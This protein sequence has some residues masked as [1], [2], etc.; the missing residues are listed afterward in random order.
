M[1]L[2]ETEIGAKKRET[3]FADFSRI[4]KLFGER[5]KLFVENV[6]KTT[7]E[8]N[9]RG[10]QFVNLCPPPFCSLNPNRA[11]KVMESSGQIRGQEWT[12]HSVEH[13]PEPALVHRHPL[14]P[15]GGRGLSQAHRCYLW[16][17]E[18]GARDVLVVRLARLSPELRIGKA[19]ALQEGHWRE[20]DAVGHV[21]VGGGGTKVVHGK[22]EKR[23]QEDVLAKS[24]LQQGTNLNNCAN[25]PF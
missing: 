24:Q 4:A 14:K 13:R 15:F 7:L 3:E 17:G 18:H 10:I 21:T 22:K 23:L 9:N 12:C 1:V 20:V 19:V 11:G 2:R 25:E 5:P 16:V 8:D 6:W